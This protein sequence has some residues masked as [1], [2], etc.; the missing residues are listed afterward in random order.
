MISA[1][2]QA[3]FLGAAFTAAHRF[4]VAS[5][6]AFRPAAL[7]LRFFLAGVGVVLIVVPAPAF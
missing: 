3:I 7:N 4:F 1:Y 6:I 5:I 2:V